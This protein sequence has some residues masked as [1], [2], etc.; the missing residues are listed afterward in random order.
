MDYA[1]TA[2]ALL[3]ALGNEENI[4]TV[5]HC[6]TRMRFVLYD[7]TI[8]KDETVKSIPGVLGVAR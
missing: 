1:K 4:K 7:E 2:E 3:K 6:M 8:P 5:T